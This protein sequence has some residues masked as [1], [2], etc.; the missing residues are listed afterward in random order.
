LGEEPANDNELKAMLRPFPSERMT[1]WPVNKAVRNVKND[2]PD[3]IE[4]TAVQ[5]SFI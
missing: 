4:R 1:A 2:A 3:L 5:A